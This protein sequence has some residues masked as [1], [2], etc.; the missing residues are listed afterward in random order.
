MWRIND[1]F[2]ATPAHPAEMISVIA[3]DNLDKVAARAKLL[4]ETNRKTMNAFL[5]SRN[6]LEFVR[7]QHGTIVFPKLRSGNV[8]DFLRRL[9]EKYETS[10]VPGHFFD[11]PQHFRVGIGGD[12]RDDTHRLRAPRRRT[13]R[14]PA[15]AMKLGTHQAA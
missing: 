5:D 1:L 6:D 10:A 8:D 9:R 14:V 7:P 13:R 11:M 12:T 15:G 3:L 2:A 4:L